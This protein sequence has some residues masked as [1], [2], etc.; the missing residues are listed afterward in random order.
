MQ[1]RNSI[2]KHL[3]DDVYDDW[4]DDDDDDVSLIIIQPNRVLVSH[5]IR[6]E[7]LHSV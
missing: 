3:E 1:L 4:D 6:L 7:L 5:K 2:I